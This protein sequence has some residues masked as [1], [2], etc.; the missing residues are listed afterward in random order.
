MALLPWRE[1]NLSFEAVPAA[2][3][4]PALLRELE[5]S[6]ADLGVDSY[7]LE[8]TTLEEVFL[9]VSAAAAAENKAGQPRLSASGAEAGV[10]QKAETAEV[11]VDI[12]GLSGGE[13]SRDNGGKGS[14]AP[15]PLLRVRLCA[16]PSGSIQAWLFDKGSSVSCHFL[17]L[18][19]TSHHT[20]WK[21]HS[22]TLHH[23]K[24]EPSGRPLRPLLI[25]IRCLQNSCTTL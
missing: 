24:I 10:G 1:H 11:A 20:A 22:D 19:H 23:R 15:V 17:V 7:G 25:T 14:Q 3:R 2:C 13:S 18:Y 16:I 8:V 12:N 5:D 9:A 6:K 21:A 4:F